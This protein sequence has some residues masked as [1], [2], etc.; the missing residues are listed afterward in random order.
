ML[1][2]ISHI[3]LLQ[4]LLVSG[5][6]LTMVFILW[7]IRALKVQIRDAIFWIVTSFCLLLLSI[8]PQIAIRASFLLG[9]ESPFNFVLLVV[10]FIIMIKL[11][12][13]S[14]RLSRLDARLQTLAQRLALLEKEL[15][16][17]PEE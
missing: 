8:F 11:F 17:P 2:D 7:R 9:F 12:S 14:V 16:T 15:E 3:L 10:I 13:T 5:S 4:I 1:S 6:L